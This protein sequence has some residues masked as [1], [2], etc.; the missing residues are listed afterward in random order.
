MKISGLAR[1]RRIWNLLRRHKYTITLAYFAAV[2][3]YFSDNSFYHQWKQQREINSMKE[4]IEDYENKYV[5]DGKQ[6]N[7]LEH[8]PS[9]ILRIAR[10]RYLMKSKDEDIFI[11]E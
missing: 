1:L 2:L 9:A 8:D 6:L 5:H 11:V 3:F 4:E 7:D 10:E